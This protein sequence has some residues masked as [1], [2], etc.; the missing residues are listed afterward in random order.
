MQYYVNYIIIP[1]FNV[2]L[3]KSC[4]FPNTIRCI[5]LCIPGLGL[6][7]ELEWGASTFYQAIGPEIQLHPDPIVA[8]INNIA[9]KPNKKT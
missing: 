1:A 3:L 4:L 7:F 5:L 2:Q 9:N 8:L 6:Q